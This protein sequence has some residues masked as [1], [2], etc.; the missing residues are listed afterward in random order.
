MRR[1]VVGCVAIAFSV[2]A[3]A[4]PPEARKPA[5]GAWGV[6]LS[7]MDPGVKPGDDFFAHVSGKW[8][9]AAGIPPD[10]TNTGSFPDLRI[11][12][13]QRM[14]DIVTGLQMQPREQ[15][16]AEE[17]QLRDLFE[18]FVDTAQIEKNGL[19]PARK[20][21]DALASVKTRD[22]VA[23]AMG[24]P[25][26]Q[27][28]SLFASSINVDAKN[29]NAYVMVVQQSGLALPARDYYLRDDPNLAATRDAYR[30]HLAAV[31]GL[32]GW[33]DADK[34]TEAV[35]ALETAVAD[36]SWAPADRRDAS[37]TYNPMT[38]A[39][40][41]TFAPGFPWATYFEA[42]GLS[43][44][45][46][47]GARMVIVR[48][49]T[50]FPR[51]ARIFAET[52]VSVW[53]DWLTAHYLHNVSSYLPKRFDDE[54]FAFF[55]RVLVGRQTQLPRDVRAVTLLDRRLAH[56]LGKKYVARYFPPDSKAKVEALVSNL[57]KAYDADIRQIPWMTE[58]T[59]Q[60]ALD[61]LHA[62]VPHVGYPDK[63]R[64]YSGLEVKS[65]D[66]LGTITRSDLFEYRY[67]LTRIDAR[68]DRNEWNMTPPTVNA[69]YS[70]TLNSIFFPAAVLQPP[71][72]DPNA[73][74]AVN[75]GGIGAVIGHEISHGF[76]D[77][78]SKYNGAGML[79]SWW[80]DADR[81]AFDERV[82]ALGTQ[83]D[84]YE[85]LP[86]L[87]VNGKLTMGENIGDLSGLVI[88][89]KAYHIALGGK[90]APVLDTYT[91]DQRFFLAFGQI[92]REKYRDSAMRRLI[93]SDPHSPPRFRTIG[94]TRNMDEWYAAFDV[95]PGDKQFLP[96]DRRVRLW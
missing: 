18:A 86:G 85:G 39:Q 42:R 64:D 60:K 77:Q 15:L 65:D 33:P 68:V 78:G 81:A 36:V 56:P 91:G 92:W 6:D 4:A 93:L 22:D 45:G 82:S 52:P 61:K 55:G 37:K 20:D 96:P 46:P 75:Y 79:Q 41:E 10:R 67:R 71:F 76:D 32:L 69:Q 95:K 38:I 7:G 48:E 12:S 88:S 59:R 8:Y 31:F 94:P 35:F 40:L 14:K 17:R 2:C 3:A 34:R 11:L 1:L 5:L 54:D 9:A 29:P 70:P 28:D 89:L 63:W 62:F 73:D 90:P 87:H 84:G 72:F 74:D 58:A 21:L 23:R 30:K 49:N 57:L 24:A 19:T 44:T 16:S 13:E 51:L 27:T 83:Y 43:P 80:T 25:G 47:S 50:A 66:L 53:S 26:G